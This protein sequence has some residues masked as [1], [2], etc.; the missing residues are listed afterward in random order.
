MATGKLKLLK[1]LALYFIGQHGFHG[2]LSP[3]Q[4]HP[5]PELSPLPCVLQTSVPASVFQ[6]LGDCDGVPHSSEAT[7]Y[8]IMW[9]PCSKMCFD[10][11]STP[12]SSSSHRLIQRKPHFLQHLRAPNSPP[13]GP[14]CMRPLQSTGISVCN[15]Q[16]PSLTKAGLLPGS[17][18]LLSLRT[19]LCFTWFPQGTPQEGDP[20]TQRQPLTSTCPGTIGW[21]SSLT[22][23]LP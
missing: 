23:S 6:S 18:L 5:N 9:R 3:L 1:R 7:Y 12:S 2:S 13:S 20:G 10:H 14:C 19:S 4:I 11:H 17:H 22:P 8:L 21:W 16:L 15:G